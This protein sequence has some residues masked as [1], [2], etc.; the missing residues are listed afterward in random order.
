M[1]RSTSVIALI[2]FSVTN[3]GATARII[4]ATPKQT[5]PRVIKTLKGEVRV[6]TVSDGEKITA[7]GADGKTI[8]EST[9]FKDDGTY[10]QLSAFFK[11]FQEA[12]KD[13]READVIALLRFPFRVNGGGGRTYANATALKRQYRQVFTTKMVKRIAGE[14]PA[15]IF[16]RNSQAMTG[17][18]LVWAHAEAGVV[19]ADVLNRF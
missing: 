16:C 5:P 18:G 10:D 3:A 15:A 7:V 9:C 8:S 4:E 12:V 6:E 19:K 2:V 1:N 11:T 17:E 14:D 13:G